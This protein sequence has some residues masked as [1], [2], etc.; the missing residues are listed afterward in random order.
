MTAF[1]PENATFVAVSSAL[2]RLIRGRFGRLGVDAVMVCAGLGSP[3]EVCI[4]SHRKH[5]M[6]A[7]RQLLTGGI[8]IIVNSCRDRNEFV[9]LE[10][11]QRQ[12]LPAISHSGNSDS[13]V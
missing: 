13:Y 7:T 11:Y 8:I 6:V 12:R 5:G 4:V 1:C 2:P 3:K 9:K 10:V